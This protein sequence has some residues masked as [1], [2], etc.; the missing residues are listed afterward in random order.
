[1][2][3]TSYA[4]QAD[5]MDGLK[6]DI[7]PHKVVSYAAEVAIPFGR[8]VC[9][10]TDKEKQCKLPAL[11]ADITSLFAKRGVALQ[12]H[13]MENPADGLAPQYAIKKT[14]SVMT[15]GTVWVKVEDAVTPLSAPHVRFA[16]GNLGLFRSDVDGGDAHMMCELFNASKFGKPKDSWMWCWSRG[17]NRS[18]LGEYEA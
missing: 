13:A 14:V 4:Q 18:Y 15:K 10:G 6:G 11:A 3:Q 8:F 12:S 7:G 1:M 5:S 17:S 9:L 16:D 2:S